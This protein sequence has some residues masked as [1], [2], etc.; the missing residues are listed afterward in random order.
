MS[1]EPIRRSL[2]VRLNPEEAFRL[3][4]AGIG[5]WWPLDTHARAEERGSETKEVVFEE[6]AGGRIYEVLTD[7]TNCDWGRVTAWEPPGRVVYDWKPND[8]DHPPTEVEVRFSPTEKGGTMVALEHRG[9]EALGPDLGPVAR[10][11]YD[12]PDGWGLVF[13]RC[14]AEAAG[15]AG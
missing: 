5:S 9:W 4:T 3:F 1:T 11:A 14:F 6:H 10:E 12:A 2:H 7:G 15:V 13:E 8:D